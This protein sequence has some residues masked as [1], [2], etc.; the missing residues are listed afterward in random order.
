MQELT[1]LGIVI[2]GLE[3][4]DPFNYWAVPVAAAVPFGLGLVWY[5]TLFRDQWLG[6]V[7]KSV[8]ELSGTPAV[9]YLI[10]GVTALAL[11]VTALALSYVL[12]LLVHWADADDLFK[13]AFV[14]FVVWLVFVAATSGVNAIFAGRPRTLWLIDAG[15]WL[16]SLVL[17]GAILGGWYTP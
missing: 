4:V 9:G 3:K 2:F 5:S 6:A 8:D 16:V 17:M 1:S 15:Y 13:G 14:G 10:S 11:G 7:G 12:G